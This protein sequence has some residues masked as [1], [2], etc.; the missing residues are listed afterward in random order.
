MDPSGS[1]HC[2]R[3][4]APEIEHAHEQ[5]DGGLRLAVCTASAKGK[6]WPTASQGKPWD[7][8]VARSFAWLE[9]IRRSWIE[10]ETV[11]SVMENETGAGHH[12]ARAK[13]VEDAL[14]Q[15]HD[16]PIAVG[17]T[18]VD[19]VTCRRSATSRAIFRR[20]SGGPFAGSQHSAQRYLDMGWITDVSIAIP[21]SDQLA[22][23]DLIDERRRV[24]PQGLDV[25]S[26]EQPQHFQH[27]DP[28][29]VGRQLAHRCPA[30]VSF[31]RRH[32]LPGMRGDI[33][34]RQQSAL[35]RNNLAYASA[36]ISPVQDRSALQR[37]PLERD[38]QFRF[39]D[40]VSW[41]WGVPTWQEPR[42]AG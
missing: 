13:R 41:R 38:R 9:Y 30:V 35:R 3:H 17:S 14:D 5:L 28:L 25:D 19:G 37:D 20:R 39:S 11:T 10:I 33:A 31:E 23:G 21:E 34:L 42:G 4:V 12:D 6:P 26:L 2:G 8:R 15:A 40:S 36:D 1:F 24:L 29:R 16:Q 18:E 22:S 7:Q 32:P 27:D